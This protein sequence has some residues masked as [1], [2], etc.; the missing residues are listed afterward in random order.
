MLETSYNFLVTTSLDV[1]SSELK[2]KHQIL[3]TPTPCVSGEPHSC[4]GQPHSVLL[5]SSRSSDLGVDPRID[6]TELGA[7][8]ERWVPLGSGDAGNNP[9]C[10]RGWPL[11]Q[12]AGG[13]QASLASGGA[14]WSTFWRPHLSL[15]AF[16][17]QSSGSFR[18]RIRAALLLEGSWPS[19]LEAASAPW[20][21][22]T[23]PC[24]NHWVLAGGSS[25]ALST[26]VHSTSLS[27]RH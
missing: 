9:R 6:L 14:K 25:Q 10:G 22:R 21:P 5:E 12:E 27:V 2:L 13:A 26:S 19:A 23:V 15:C 20:L 1:S 16:R 18:N 17:V 7:C 4:S 11:T 3:T 24:R 8:R